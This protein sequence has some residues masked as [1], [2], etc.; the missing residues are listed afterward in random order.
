MLNILL[1]L[2]ELLF[3][4][5]TL[6]DFLVRMKLLNV[7]RKAIVCQYNDLSSVG[8]DDCSGNLSLFILLS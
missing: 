1:L 6:V 8:A 4:D 7:F 3:A 2:N 5:V